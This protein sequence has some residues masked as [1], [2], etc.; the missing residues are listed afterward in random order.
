MVCGFALNVWQAVRYSAG[1]KSSEP[2]S[3]RAKWAWIISVAAWWTG[4][5]A[6]L[7]APIGI[8]LGAVELQQSTGRA[9]RLAARM[10]VFNGLWVLLSFSALIVVVLIFHPKRT[11]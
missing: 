6:I 11:G 7:G 9:T 4:P 10:A 5:L 3:S 1:S 2:A 8:I